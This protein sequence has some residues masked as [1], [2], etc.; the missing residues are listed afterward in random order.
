[1]RENGNMASELRNSPADFEG[2]MPGGSKRPGWQAMPHSPSEDK[3]DRRNP[4]PLLLDAYANDNASLDRKVN[5][6]ESILQNEAL[7][8]KTKAGALV[9]RL[10]Q[11]WHA[12]ISIP[13]AIMKLWWQDTFARAPAFLGGKK[14]GRLIAAYDSG[15]FDLVEKKLRQKKLAPRIIGNA[16]TALARALIARK[17]LKRACEASKRAYEADPQY[18]RLKWHA[19]RLYEAGNAEEADLLL[20]YLQ[21]RISFSTSELKTYGEI[22]REAW[23]RN[24]HSA[25]LAL[26]D[27]LEKSLCG[28]PRPNSGHAFASQLIGKEQDLADICLKDG[29]RACMLR[30]RALYGDNPDLVALKLVEAAFTLGENAPGLELALLREAVAMAPSLANIRTLFWAASKCGKAWEA[31]TALAEYENRLQPES[32]AYERQALEKMNGTEIGQLGVLNQLSVESAPAACQPI[33]K[34][35]CYVLH[36]SLPWRSRGY[37]TRGIGVAQ[38]LAN[39]GYELIC[40]TRPGYPLD[41]VEGLSADGLQEDEY[42]G[43]V[44][45]V[46]ILEPMRNRHSSREYL[47]LAANALK[48]KLKEL[49]PQLVLAA[50]NYE[51]A[52]PTLIAS[53]RLGIP[54]IYEVRG[55]WELTRLSRQR[56]FGESIFFN[57]QKIFETEICKRAD[58]VLTLTHGL[59]RELVTRGVEEGKI[60]IAPN[61]C[62]PEMFKP[63]HKKPDA[64]NVPDIP[65][66]V[67]VIGY[68]GTFVD[69]EGLDLL[70]E[71]CILLKK[72]GR[73]FRLM[74]LGNNLSENPEIAMGIKSLARDGGLADWLVML[75]KVPFEKV[76]QY[77]ALVDICAFPRRAVPVCEI[78]SPLKPMEAM[79]MARAIVVSS[80][81]A[82]AE[83]VCDGE[84]GLVFE[85]ENVRDLAAKLEYLLDNP[86]ICQSLGQSARKFVIQERSWD[87]IGGIMDDTIQK[88]LSDKKGL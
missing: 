44:R 55:L 45:H 25:R 49:Q 65:A 48:E 74:L 36:N 35:I 64:T 2:A 15:G 84:T 66:N 53:R 58:H 75:G 17:E 68:I 61:A 1:M 18:Y 41:L 37:A 77:Y 5:L 39:R 52:L 7:S 10:I 73:K 70:V 32:C 31:F 69:Y 59:K 23:R 11:K 40:L 76:P 20:A 87:K 47:E 85:K 9:E 57:I 21:D 38:A 4:L 13:L 43:G 28:A 8:F 3:A 54:F 26:A 16:Y 81:G 60:S 6:L 30:A 56:E 42:V 62:N 12:P 50:S 46:R 72:R 24:D 27:R 86:A 71:A 22:N 83:M 33:E 80:V 67:P 51:T 63:G 79:S 19:F 88:V 82:L 78:V 14:F 34:R 29:L